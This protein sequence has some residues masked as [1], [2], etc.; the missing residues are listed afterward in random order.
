MSQESCSICGGDGRIMNSFGN[1]NRCPSCHGTGRRSDDG[2]MRDVTKTKPSHHRSA[3]TGPAVPVVRAPT[4][5]VGVRLAEEVRD[6]ATISAET[7]AKLT[8]EIIEYEES[9]GSCTQTF[10]KK[11]R[12]Q[13]K[14]RA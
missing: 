13:L 9:H 7:K 12:K 1:V 5:A 3:P 4:S 6:S 14:P 10:L 11:V 2:G 8:L